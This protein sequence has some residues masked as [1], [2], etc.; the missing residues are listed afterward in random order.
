MSKSGNSIANQD[1]TGSATERLKNKAA[2]VR[3][4]LQELGAC[5]KDVAREK[6]AHLGDRASE[7]GDQGREKVAEFTQS[8]EEYVRAKPVKSLLIAAGAGFVAALL[9]RRP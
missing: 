7:Y 5:V 8:I 1:A 9:L 4:E 2:D 6:V 3:E